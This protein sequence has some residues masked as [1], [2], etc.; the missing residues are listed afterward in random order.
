MSSLKCLSPG[1]TR[2]KRPNLNV[3]HS[4]SLL[5][6]QPELRVTRYFYYLFALVLSTV[7]GTSM[8]Q[9][10]E[11][12]QERGYVFDQKYVKRISIKQAEQVLGSPGLFDALLSSNWGKEVIK[13][14]RVKRA[15]DRLVLEFVGKTPLSLRDFTRKE[16]IQSEGD[17]Q[18]FKYIK[19]VRGYH[20]V[21]V[22]FG[23]DQ[24][25]FLL[26]AYSGNEIY[27]VD[28]N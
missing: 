9:S 14:G 13:D 2:S 24:P 28:T 16:T 6:N 19:G 21:G 5:V 20:L 27:F 1:H 10:Y 15:G 3:S 4:S 26:V 7:C 18:T 12:G 8:A 11:Y 22:E 17:A 23:H 25:A